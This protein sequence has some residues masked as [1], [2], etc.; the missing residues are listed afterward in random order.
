MSLRRAYRPRPE[1]SRFPAACLC[2]PIKH[3]SFLPIDAL[4]SRNLARPAARSSS[5]G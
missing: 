4:I 3:Q 5:L 2:S 1:A